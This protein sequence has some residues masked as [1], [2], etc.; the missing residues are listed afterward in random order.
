MLN[1]DILSE[2]VKH[3]WD[4]RLF[5]NYALVCKV[6]RDLCRKMIYQDMLYR[7]RFCKMTRSPYGIQ[8]LLPNGFNHGY[9]CFNLIN[10]IPTFYEFRK[11]DYGSVLFNLNRKIQFIN[12]T[13]L[14][15]PSLTLTF[16]YK[17]IGVN[18]RKYKLSTKFSKMNMF[19]LGEID[20]HLSN[21]DR[22]MFISFS[23][24]H[25]TINYNYNRKFTYSVGNNKFTVRKF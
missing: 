18:I 4:V 16:G 24:N 11:Y 6:C 15:Y 13:R 17:H 22:N 21:Y 9:S 10:E 5:Y 8:H 14:D 20:I 23:K 12:T 3:I 1:N 7:M 2:I 25:V 19:K